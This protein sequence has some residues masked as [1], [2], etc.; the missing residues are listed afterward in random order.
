MFIIIKTQC[1]TYM[2]ICLCY[3]LYVIINT[4]NL[5]TRCITHIHTLI[6]SKASDFP[7]NSSSR[8][9]SHFVA[10]SPFTMVSKVSFSSVSGQQKVRL[11]RVWRGGFVGPDPSENSFFFFKIFFDVDHF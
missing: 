6:I 2:L 10:P 3:V 7:S 5:R 1:I 11:W 4:A 8:V 9:Q